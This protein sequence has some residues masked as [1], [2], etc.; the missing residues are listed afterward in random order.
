[1]IAACP[2][3]HHARGCALRAAAVASS[4]CV[5]VHCVSSVGPDNKAPNWE[6]RAPVDVGEVGLLDGVGGASTEPPAKCRTEADSTTRQQQRRLFPAPSAILTAAED[7]SKCGI[8]S[9][10]TGCHVYGKQLPELAAVS[11]VILA[12]CPLLSVC[13]ER[14]FGCVVYLDVGEDEEQAARSIIFLALGKSY[15]RP[16]VNQY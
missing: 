1:M 4:A 12:P 8:L 9:A 6:H 15:G 16:L 13:G 2:D 14:S 3:V 7:G 5:C 10:R 11:D